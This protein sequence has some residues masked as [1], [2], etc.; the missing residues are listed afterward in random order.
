MEKVDE[1]PRHEPG[2][3]FPILPPPHPEGSLTSPTFSQERQVEESRN[4][5]D[6]KMRG[7]N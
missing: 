2:V 7:G 5:K 4:R 6:G 3:H 1:E